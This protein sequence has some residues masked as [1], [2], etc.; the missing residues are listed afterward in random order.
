MNIM[1]YTGEKNKSLQL[2]FLAYCL[3]DTDNITYIVYKESNSS[4]YYK[5]M[6]IT[7]NELE[8]VLIPKEYIEPRPCG[9]KVIFEQE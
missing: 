6:K 5:C 9:Y 1:E 4:F 2:P 3:K 7:K 8:I